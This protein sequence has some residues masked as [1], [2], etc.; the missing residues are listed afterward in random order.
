LVGPA[1]DFN[2]VYFKLTKV[3]AT[4]PDMPPI[5]KF[6]SLWLV[7]VGAGT[8]GL[9]MAACVADILSSS[10]NFDYLFLISAFKLTGN[11]AIES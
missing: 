5:K 2:E 3:V 7:E 9:G 1:F 8:T 6:F 10:L 11:C 4:I